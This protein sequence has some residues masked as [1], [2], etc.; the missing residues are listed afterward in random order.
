MHLAELTGVLPLQFIWDGVS[1]QCVGILHGSS[2]RWQGTFAAV[3]GIFR[4]VM[5]NE[6]KKIE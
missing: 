4:A 1:G 2:G 6:K 3:S 5:Q